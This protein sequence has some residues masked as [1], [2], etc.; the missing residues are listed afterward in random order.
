MSNPVVGPAIPIPP[1][2]GA[3]A[4]AAAPSRGA[5]FGELVAQ[6]RASASASS[7]PPPG[8]RVHGASIAPG[9]LGALGGQLLARVARG[10]HY[11]ESLV[12]QSLSGR[13]FSN[14]ELLAMQAQVYRCTQELDLV[15]R[16]VDR[17]TS[18][19]RTVL[20]QNG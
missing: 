1:P 2:H 7:G 14:A 4:S 15:S 8:A 6:R 18:T 16:L 10:E 17:G 19:V 13:A 5:S 3:Q 20:T 12:R 11:V 9:T